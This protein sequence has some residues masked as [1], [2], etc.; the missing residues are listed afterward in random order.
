[1]QARRS[2]LL[3]AAAL[4]CACARETP[5]E[6]AEPSAPRPGETAPV[7][8]TPAPLPPAT[9]TQPAAKAEPAGEIALTASP[10]ETTENSTVTLALRNGSKQQIG[11]NLCT[12]TLQTADGRDVPTS[13]VCTMELR[14]LEPGRTDSYRYRLPVNMAE[15]SYRFAAQVERMPNGGMHS[16][17]SNLFTVGPD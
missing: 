13:R 7:D 16:I 1:M 14:T 2:A 5:N 17:R 15:G 10:A 8:G 9:P 11:Y 6:S 3:C 4:L 12:S